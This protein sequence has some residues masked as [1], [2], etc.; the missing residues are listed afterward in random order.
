M[1]TALVN[2]KCVFEKI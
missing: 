2:M 1:V